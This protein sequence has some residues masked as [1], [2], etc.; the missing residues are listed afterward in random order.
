MLGTVRG[1]QAICYVGQGQLRNPEGVK[2]R[3]KESTAIP[4]PGASFTCLVK[5]MRK[6]QRRSWQLAALSRKPSD[7][8]PAVVAACKVSHRYEHTQQAHAHKRK[9][10]APY[11]Y[12][13]VY[14]YIH[15]QSR[16]T[17]MYAYTY[18]YIYI[19]VCV[20]VCL[21]V[22]RICNICVHN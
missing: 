15:I 21:C 18:I 4:K 19:Y 3:A 12:I 7:S 13:S 2:R 22:S 20:C 16:E 8:G 14:I 9:A 1:S 5:I 11:V 10:G 6:Y 17:H